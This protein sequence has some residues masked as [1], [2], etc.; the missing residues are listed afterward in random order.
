MADL[1]VSGIN[2]F[3]DLLAHRRVFNPADLDRAEEGVLSDL[4]HRL[5]DRALSAHRLGKGHE[6]HNAEGAVVTPV[7]VHGSQ[8]LFD[9]QFNPA[10]PGFAGCALKLPRS[11]PRPP[12]P[13]AAAPRRYGLPCAG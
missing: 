6:V 2:N 13:C 3:L 5:G 4:G 1:D 12:S 9:S 11:R 10:A 7:F 8:L